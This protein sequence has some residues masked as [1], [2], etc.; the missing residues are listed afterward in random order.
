MFVVACPDQFI[1]PVFVIKTGRNRHLTHIKYAFPKNIQATM[2]TTIVF[3]R[4]S[5][6]KVHVDTLNIGSVKAAF[7]NLLIYL[8][9]SS[10]KKAP[11]CVCVCVFPTGGL[12]DGQCGTPACVSPARHLP[13]FHGAAHHPADALRLPAGLRQGEQG[14]YRLPVPAQLVCADS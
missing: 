4:R 13:D 5:A 8:F 10:D 1:L 12:R 7:I 3:L 2:C 9:G 6:F 14:Q 11:L